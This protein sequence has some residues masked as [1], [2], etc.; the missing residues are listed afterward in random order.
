MHRD[1]L[2]LDAESHSRSS[3]IRTPLRY[4]SNGR[5]P[6]RSGQRRRLQSISQRCARAPRGGGRRKRRTKT[7][8]DHSGG[9]ALG[10]GQLATVQS[11]KALRQ[12]DLYSCNPFRRSFLSAAVNPEDRSEY[13][14]MPIACFQELGRGTRAFVIRDSGRWNSSR[15]GVAT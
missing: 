5:Q 6:W 13:S 10:Q 15:D 14:N 1:S 4:L 3:L 8:K 9:A 2:M 11:G 12:R 7:R